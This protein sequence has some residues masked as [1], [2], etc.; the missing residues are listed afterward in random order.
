MTKKNIKKSDDLDNSNNDLEKKILELQAKA[1]V[2]GPSLDEIRT[3][4]Q[5][6]LQPESAN[7]SYPEAAVASSP[8]AWVEQLYPEDHVV[9]FRLGQK[10]FKQNYKMVNGTVTL[11][12]TATEVKQAYVKAAAEGC[13]TCEEELLKDDRKN[14][15]KAKASKR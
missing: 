15:M 1:V 14:V 5:K 10:T 6:A 4:V 13:L 12:G 3:K 7:K 9:I 8:M 2:S 11:T